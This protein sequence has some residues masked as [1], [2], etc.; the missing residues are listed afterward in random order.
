MADAAS[1]R[2]AKEAHVTGHGGS[3]GAEVF[4]VVIGTAVWSIMAH[5]AWTA[6]GTYTSL[7]ARS[8]PAVITVLNVLRL[9]LCPL[10]APAHM[11]LLRA[12]VL[13][14]GQSEVSFSPQHSPPTSFPS[15]K[16]AVVL[17]WI[18]GAA[19][20]RSDRDV[21][22]GP[23]LVW[24]IAVLHGC[25]ARHVRCSCG[26]GFFSSSLPPPDGLCTICLAARSLMVAS[27]H[28]T[29]PLLVFGCEAPR[30]P[31]TPSYLRDSTSCQL[32]KIYSHRLWC[33]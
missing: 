6:T 12:N 11:P 24:A 1:V 15:N 13:A 7:K 21:A 10:Q 16:V 9:P 31:P 3:S 8:A 5:R 17:P 25:G 30:Y 19:C 14:A 18:R 22:N 4:G 28:H 29:T 27:N 33:V 23:R 2:A 26:K 32:S 20:N